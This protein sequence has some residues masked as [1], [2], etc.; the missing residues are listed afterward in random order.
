[1]TCC[2]PSSLLIHAHGM[3]TGRLTTTHRPPICHPALH[4]LTDS[5]RTVTCAVPLVRTGA[6]HA[7]QLHTCDLLDLCHRDGAADEALSL[8][9]SMEDQATYVEVQTHAHC[10]RSYHDAVL[11]A[12][13]IEQLGL[14]PP[15]LGRQCAIHHAHAAEKCI[16]ILMMIREAK[17]FSSRVGVRCRLQLASVLVHDSAQ[18]AAQGN[19][20][21]DAAWT[22]AESLSWGGLPDVQLCRSQSSCQTAAAETVDTLLCVRKRATGEFARPLMLQGLRLLLQLC[23]VAAAP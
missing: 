4:K 5:L 19:K 15:H 20:F 21:C 22:A 3:Y 8:V 14:L 23:Q 12:G 11:V 6:Q 16:V 17:T 7:C 18:A 2:S 9:Q 1:M 13:L 10:I